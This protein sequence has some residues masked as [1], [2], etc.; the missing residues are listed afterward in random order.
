MSRT[1]SDV[2]GVRTIADIVDDA[3]PGGLQAATDEEVIATADAIIDR[4][5]AR[6]DILGLSVETTFDQASGHWVAPALVTQVAADNE[7]LGFANAG[8]TLGTDT[9]PEE[10]ARDIV[11]VVQ[12]DEAT[13][14][15]W[16]IAIDVNLT[17]QEQGQAAGPFIGFTILAVL[18]IVGIVFRSYWSIA[19]TGAALGALIVWLY[20]ISN[21]IGLEVDLILSL[22]VPIAMI[23]FGV[24]FTFHALGRYQ[25]E[26]RLGYVPRRAFTVGLSA[27]IGA[28]VL[29]LLSDTAA[30]LANASS[31]IESIIQFGVAT[32]IALLAAFFLLG[33]VTPLTIATIEHRIG[34]VPRSRM[35]TAG[36]V[37][38]QTLAGILAM[39]AVLMM[40]YIEPA[41]GVAALAIYVVAALALP[42]LLSRRR[43]I[44]AAPLPHGGV[45]SVARTLGRVVEA[46]AARRRYV[47]PLA[48]G[49]TVA[50]AFLAVQ[51]PTEFDVRD[52]F[53][54]D[55]E[56]VV[57]LDKVDQHIGERGGEPATIYVN[58]DLS[59]PLTVERLDVFRSDLQG[60]ESD[61]LA[62]GETGETRVLGSVL[63]VIEDVANAPFTSSAVEAA[64]GVALTDTDG[65]GIPDD[66]AQLAAI[67]AFTRRA[68]ITA[69]GERFIQ[70]P[71]D[72][73][74]NL[75]Q[76]DNGERYG[77][78]FTVQLRDTRRQ[79]SVV[80]ARD[81]LSP[82]VDEL[83][84]DLAASDAE[85]VVQADRRPNRAPGK[86]R[87][88]LSRPSNLPADRSGCMLPDRRRFHAVG[89]VR[90]RQHRPDPDDGRA[91][92]RLHGVGR[93]LDQHRYRDYRCGVDRD[94]H[95]LR[96]PLR[97]A[98]PRGARPHRR[99]SYGG[100]AGRGRDRRCFAVLGRVKRGRFLHPFVRTDADVRSLWTADCGDDCDGCIGD[101]AGSA[102]SAGSDHQG[103]GTTDS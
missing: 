52:F 4:L 9:A 31:G 65:N 76:A 39:T 70:T 66:P 80:A 67:Y 92:L 3:L 89:P 28:L 58:A 95:R 87:S 82:L 71:N 33:I 62:R 59:D 37:G 102:E 15:V 56:F 72:V 10:Y 23:S 81:A 12:G 22:I 101:A 69:D 94:W 48:L 97:H 74:Q 2:A 86:P 77:T 24:D 35:R 75:W 30:F 13:L 78:T 53:A 44:D 6:S 14:Q 19:V 49:T 5:G 63:D 73:N 38:A 16:G 99:T 42:A 61:S 68:G 103:S 21:L 27:V 46:T 83:R 25:E 40:V 43:P 20:G 60:L 100:S 36:R 45:G 50:A 84:N 29:A 93:L 88:D 91:P 55:T 90:A 32:S 8:V 64:S 41:I 18:I 98:I 96:D 7:V 1:G 57:A 26:R 34:T 17:S 11:A 79:E 47:V 54:E 51:V 85:A